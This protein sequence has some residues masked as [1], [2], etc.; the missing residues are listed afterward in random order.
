MPYTGHRT[1]KKPPKRLL[2]KTPRPSELELNWI[3][4]KNQNFM[5]F[6]TWNRS[7][8]IG[9]EDGI[10]SAQKFKESTRIGFTE[11]QLGAILASLR[12]GAPVGMGL[13]WPNSRKGRTLDNRYFFPSSARG[14]RPGHAVVAIGFVKS[15]VLPGGGCLELRNSWGPEWADEGY[16]FVSFEYLRKY[17]FSAYNLKSFR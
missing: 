12:A 6:M 10:V 15:G 9:S 7:L 14:T 2:D 13:A 8:I 1:T 11:G 4:P 17:G 16:A 3:T 5:F